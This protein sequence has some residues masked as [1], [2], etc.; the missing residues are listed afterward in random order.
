MIFAVVVCLIFNFHPRVSETSYEI[1]G[2]APLGVVE[3][4]CRDAAIDIQDF[5]IVKPDRDVLDLYH[6]IFGY[7]CDNG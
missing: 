3:S 4:F 5:M 2:S 7:S 1:T 6:D